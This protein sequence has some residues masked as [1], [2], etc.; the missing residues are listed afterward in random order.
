LNFERP[1][2]QLRLP[3]NAFKS[4]GALQDDIEERIARDLAEKRMVGGAR[5]KWYS[6]PDKPSRQLGLTQE[7]RKWLAQHVRYQRE[8][9][10]NPLQLRRDARKTSPETEALAQWYASDG[11]EQRKPSRQMNLTRRQRDFL[12]SYLRRSRNNL[13]TTS[14]ELKQRH[15]AAWLTGRPDPSAPEFIDLN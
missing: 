2:V 3:E 10:K 15:H 7:Q 4:R 5:D 14:P 1:E 8:V 6:Q 12:A 9:G 13:G 11:D